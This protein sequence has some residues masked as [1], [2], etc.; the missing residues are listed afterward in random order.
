MIKK[1]KNSLTIKIC[2]L[3][4][5]LLALSSGITYAVIAGFLPTYYSKQLQKDID[6]VSQAMIET[7][8][9]YKTIDEAFYAIALFEAGSKVSV[10]LLDER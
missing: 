1:I 2:I 3:V 4:A 8:R 5:V 9:S 6:A 7:I 10:V